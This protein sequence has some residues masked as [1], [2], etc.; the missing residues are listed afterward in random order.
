MILGGVGAPDHNL[1]RRE[2][3]R[4]EVHL[5][6]HRLEKPF[7][8]IGARVVIDAGRV[9]IE[10]L[11]VEQLFRGADVADACEQFFEIIRV[12]VFQAFVIHDEALD[13]KFRERRRRPPPELRAARGAD[14]E[15]DGHDHRQ[16]VV[17]DLPLDLPAAFGL[18]Y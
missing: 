10:H 7:R 12:G 1:R 2:P 14:P 18:N 3:V 6:L 11:F 13:Q 9:D 17:G 8:G 15:A 4:G 16:I 5:V